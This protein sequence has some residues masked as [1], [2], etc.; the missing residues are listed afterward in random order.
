MNTLITKMTDA[1]SRMVLFAA[2]IAMAGLGFAMLGMLAFFALIG[3]A[4]AF[5]AAP[6]VRMPQQDEDQQQAVA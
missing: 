1:L 4:V 6:F 5:L 2:A 3:L